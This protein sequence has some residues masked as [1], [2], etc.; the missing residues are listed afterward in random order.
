MFDIGWS[1]LMVVGAL[2]LIV[3]GPRDLPKLLQQFGKY[4]AQARRM[5]ADFQRSMEDAAREADLGK[6]KEMRD[7][8]QQL[9]DITRSPF[10]APSPTAPTRTSASAPATPAAP[11]G[12]IPPSPAPPQTG[13]ATA[14]EPDVAPREQ[15]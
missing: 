8:A 6:M 3:V 10:Q 7:T 14:A 11:P 5:A 4:T 1:E 2:A 9:R 15:A 12:V 13:A